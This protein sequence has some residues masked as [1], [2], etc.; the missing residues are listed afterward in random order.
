MS[1][2]PPSAASPSSSS[3]SSPNRCRSRPPTPPALLPL[4]FL[5]LRLSAAALDAVEP[6]THRA[7]TPGSKAP[8]LL[9]FVETGPK[10]RKFT[11][12]THSL[13]PNSS[14]KGGGIALYYHTSLPV[15]RLPDKYCCHLLGLP[16]SQDDSSGI[17]WHLVRSTS[18]APFLL[19]VAY[20]PPHAN[21]TRT[22][23]T[24][25]CDNITAVTS[26]PVYA[27]YPFL[28]VGDLN[29]RH[30]DWQDV[31]ASDHHSAGARYLAAFVASRD[32]TILNNDY[33]PGECTRPN[34]ANPR[35]AGSVLDL[36][37]TDSDSLCSS[38]TLEY[39]DHFTSDHYP[40]YLTL[41]P[42]TSAVPPPPPHSRPRQQWC[43]HRDREYWTRQLGPQL[44]TSL[45]TSTWTAAQATLTAPLPAGSSHQ[46]VLT[47]AYDVFESAF[48]S[49]CHSLVGTKSTTPCSKAWWSYPGV[50]QAHRHL[51]LANSNH[52]LYPTPM[53]LAAV[54]TAKHKYKEL[55]I[56]AKE[57]HYQELCELVSSP[58]SKLY[59][60][61][62]RRTAGSKHAS[63]T[64][65]QD[66]NNVLPASPSASLNNLADAFVAASV[67]ST[68]ASSTYKTRSDLIADW[69]SPHPPPSRP[70]H[71][72]PT[73][74]S[75][76]DT[77]TWLFTAD[78]VKRQCT[79]QHTKSAPGP[80]AVLPIFLKHAG[81]EAYSALAALFQYSWDHSVL[82]QAWKEANVMALYKGSGAHNLPSSFRPISM[83]SIIV[84]TFEHLIH[85]RIVRLLSRPSST[86]AF[87]TNQ[88]GFRAG[89][90][91]SDAVYHLVSTIQHIMQGGT[92]KSPS[93]Q[94]SVVAATSPPLPPPPNPIL[95][96]PPSSPLPFPSSSAAPPSSPPPP[97]TSSVKTVDS[98][99]VVFLDIRK[100]FDRVDHGILLYHLQRAGIGGKAWH[101]I[102]AFLLDRRFRTVSQSASSHWHTL[103]YGVP[104][105]CV[106]SPLL[107]L[108]F[109]NPAITR[110]ASECPTVAPLFFADDGALAPNLLHSSTYNIGK[111]RRGLD[112]ALTILHD[113]CVDSRMEFGA[114]KTK[115]VLFTRR[116]NKASLI[117]DWSGLRIGPL[118]IG[119]QDHY[120]YL[121]INL[122]DKL[123]FTLHRRDAISK[124][125]S[126]SARLTSIVRHTPSPHFPTIRQLVVGY[127]LPRITYGILFWGHSLPDSER[128]TLQSCLARPLRYCLSLPST[129][130]QLGVLVE[131]NIP[132]LTAVVYHADL[133]LL[134]RV[135]DLAERANIR[136]S[137]LTASTI[138]KTAAAK[139]ARSHPLLRLHRLNTACA[140][141]PSAIFLTEYAI[142]PSLRAI[143]YSLPKLWIDTRDATASNQSPSSRPLP[144]PHSAL[145]SSATVDQW[146]PLVTPTTSRVAWL[147]ANLTK[148]GL[149]LLL[150][151]SSNYSS[152]LTKDTV[153]AT[154]MWAT[155]HEWRNDTTHPTTSHLLIA[156]LEPGRS[157]HL[158]TD[159][160][161]VAR[162]RTRLRTNRAYTQQ[163]LHRFPRS[164][165]P[166]PGPHCQHPPCLSALITES[167][168]HILL[169]CPQ[170]STSRSTLRQQLDSLLLPSAPSPSS[171]PVSPSDQIHLSLL[172]IL[173]GASASLLPPALRP[174]RPSSRLTASLLAL[175]TTFLSSI[176]LD[177]LTSGHRALHDP[178]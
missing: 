26:D 5:N 122:D 121:G 101:W 145:P 137:T 97:S 147:R 117:A 149:S 152:L 7:S 99:P 132:S 73:T 38:L 170:H 84:R 40:L 43:Q 68:T 41:T 23:M 140:R 175:T 66:I 76:S 89:R 88:Y 6:F 163:T 9:A 130:H 77:N 125:R 102:R 57:Y 82:P 62:F 116:Q 124:A 55:A 135:N 94:P 75:A 28:L 16:P 52:R 35:L 157:P 169:L 126:D 72:D 67:P 31:Q 83:T 25:L 33:I 113:W 3:S 120:T 98:C 37:I 64:S 118:T 13:L 58:D 153:A 142:N 17:L 123:T 129:T 50:Q 95:S 36:A 136:L 34:P 144:P 78:D 51:R 44:K 86:S 4:L 79:H 174:T 164:D 91:T 112:D 53:T 87:H 32:L 151:W 111:Y 160:P 154:K 168:E 176:T 29:A 161:D 171:F 109:I 167:V 47:A 46:S 8:M 177:R 106:L 42:T 146:D 54:K 93:V 21:N 162:L 138:S 56:K 110:I 105:G 63:L 14:N 90:S 10:P 100:A 19:A 81:D 85:H 143:T 30:G 103:Q 59:W 148:Q 12:F 133:S 119:I 15:E 178:G 115:L 104:Q 128:R 27:A 60:S 70:R 80:D 114:D 141:Q 166:V 96:P 107:F 108:I 2:P 11:R 39:K 158:Y 172:P 18:K 139:L 159:K 48:L 22:A 65:I 156:K 71:L 173:L 49:V 69:L 150:A 24:A 45:H 1:N 61:A 20:V 131:A 74:P 155:H 165:T 134:L 127:Q 92:K